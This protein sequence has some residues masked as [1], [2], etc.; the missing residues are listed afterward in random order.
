MIT[1]PTAALMLML[2]IHINAQAQQSDQGTATGTYGGAYITVTY[3]EAINV[4]AGPKSA[5]YPQLGELAV[6]ATAPALGRSPGGDWVE[7]SFPASPD[8]KG[9]VYAYL[10]QV[11]G[12]LLPIVEPPPTPTPPTTPTLDPTYLNVPPA[13]PTATRLPT[14]TPPPSLVVPQFSN[15]VGGSKGGFGMGY[16]ILILMLVGGAGYLIFGLRKS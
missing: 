16:L 9:W 3:I 15:E 5:F 14:F 13:Q 4:R 10:V 2:G 12:G 11:S 6:G 1:L 8:G 7:I